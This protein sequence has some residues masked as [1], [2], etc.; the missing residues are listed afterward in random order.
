MREKW[1]YLGPEGT[2]TEQAALSLRE[3]VSATVDLVPT[4]SVPAALEAVRSGAAEAA[5]VPLENSVEGIVALTQDELIHGPPLVIAAEAYVSIRFDL[6]VRNGFPVADIRTIGSHPHG[7]AQVRDHLAQ[8]FPGAEAVVTTST[9]AAAAQVA[10]GLL[11]AAACAPVAGRHHGLV[12]VAQDIGAGSTPITRFVQLRSAD[13]RP[14]PS[15]ADRTSLVV[16][17]PNV[18]G[19]L[20]GLLTEIADRDINLTRIE[21]RPTRELMGEYL[22]ILDADGHADDEPLRELLAGLQRRGVLLRFLGSYPRG[23]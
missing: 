12:S 11:D 16:T 13:H 7:H 8:H 3:G 23:H 5:V 20:V 6:L 10:E 17:V 2:F 21:S 1:A 22:F 18:P 19:S 9:A 4:V 15:G 14:P